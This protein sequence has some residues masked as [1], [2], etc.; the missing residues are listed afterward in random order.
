MR[1]TTRIA[2]RATEAMDSAVRMISIYTG[3]GV[4]PV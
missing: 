1:A 2:P 4:V 3:L